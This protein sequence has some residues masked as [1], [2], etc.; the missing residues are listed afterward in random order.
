MIEQLRNLESCDN[1]ELLILSRIESF[2]VELQYEAKLNDLKGFIGTFWEIGA[3]WEQFSHET[4]HAV[5]KQAISYI[6]Q[7]MYGISTSL[8]DGVSTLYDITPQVK[9]IKDILLNVLEY[10]FNH[11]H[12]I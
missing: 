1:D 3:M 4:N 8:L 7:E 11:I 9:R 12:I 5:L 6:L 2:T 10:E